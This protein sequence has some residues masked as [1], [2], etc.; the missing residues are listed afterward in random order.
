MLLAV[1][2]GGAGAKPAPIAQLARGRTRPQMP[3]M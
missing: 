2:A 3:Q 1:I